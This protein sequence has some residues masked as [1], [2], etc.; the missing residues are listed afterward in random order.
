MVCRS[1]IS[2]ESRERDGR[3]TQA[4]RA[5]DGDLGGDDLTLRSADLS[6]VL[7]LQSD[8][9]SKPGRYVMAVS[10]IG[11][12]FKLLSELDLTLSNAFCALRHL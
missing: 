2:S 1:Q 12:S 5:R 9:G 7:R 6:A 10:I 8:H 4:T 11:V 3:Q